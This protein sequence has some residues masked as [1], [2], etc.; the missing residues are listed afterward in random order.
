MSTSSRFGVATAAG[1]DK[2]G[3]LATYDTQTP[4]YIATLAVV[5]TEFDTLVQPALLTGA[6]TVNVG[7]GSSTT[8]PYKGDSLTLVFNSD[9]TGRTVTLGTGLSVTATTIVIPGSKKA[10]IFFT[11]DG[12]TWV[13][14]GRAIT[15]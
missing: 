6:M 5:T 14:G 1:Q 11:F 2:T 4:A 9:A 10:S 8:A 15:I 3:R 13:E 7:V 12:A